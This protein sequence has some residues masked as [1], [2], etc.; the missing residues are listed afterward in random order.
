MGVSLV[1]VDPGVQPETDADPRHLVAS[2]NGDGGGDDGGGPCGA[3]GLEIC[4]ATSP[5]KPGE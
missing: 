3:S 1:N 5:G 4:S 2:G